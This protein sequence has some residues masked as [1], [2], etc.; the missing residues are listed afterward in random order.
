[1]GT[2][3]KSDELRETKTIEVDQVG[4]IKMRPIS[5]QSTSTNRYGQTQKKNEKYE[6]FDEEEDDRPD[7]V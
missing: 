6:Q 4:Q 5:S 3:E 2:E 1:M 7:T